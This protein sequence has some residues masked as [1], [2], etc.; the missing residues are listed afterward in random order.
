MASVLPT[1]RDSE[2]RKGWRIVAASMVGIACGSSP[3]PFTSIGQLIGPVH[4]DLGWSVGQVSLAITVFGLC[5]SG[6]AP[7]VGGLADRIGVRK[8]ALAS[9][10]LFGVT[11]ACIAL[12]PANVVAW[13][14]AWGLSGLVSVG[15]GALSWTRGIGLWFLRQRGLALGVALLGTSLT[16]FFM[17]QF[18]G[19]AIDRFGWRS[20]FPMLALLPLALALPIVWLWFREPKSED[21]PAGVFAGGKPVGLSVAEA[22]RGYRFWVMIAS[23]LMIALAYAGMFVHMQQIVELAG[24]SRVEARNVVSSMALAILI[25]RVGTGFFLDRFW[26]PLVTLPVLSLPAVACILLAGDSITLPIA[27]LCA[28]SVGLASGAETDMIAYMASRYFGMAS[29]G[30]IYG[31]LFLPFGIASAVSPSLYGWARDVTGGYDAP[32]HVATVLFVAGAAI[33]LLLGRYPTFASEPP[34]AAA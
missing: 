34:R 9:L 8:V 32:L 12:T 3:V 23:I 16:G 30:R 5:A 31:L 17:P 18:A 25:G 19:W 7:I 11:F 10:A 26:A 24:Y 20:M 6:M 28:F 1:V 29:Y 21:R 27:Y 14:L 13:W 15:S 33:L 22:I 4:E 2:F